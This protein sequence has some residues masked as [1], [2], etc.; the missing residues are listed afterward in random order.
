MRLS[1]Q[2]MVPIPE[3]LTYVAVGT[4]FTCWPA[5]STQKT[6]SLRNRTHESGTESTTYVPFTSGFHDDTNLCNLGP[7]QCI[8]DLSV[9]SGVAPHVTRVSDTTGTIAST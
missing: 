5:S 4:Y 3:S 1:P 8:D 7:R 9:T 6:D 2:N